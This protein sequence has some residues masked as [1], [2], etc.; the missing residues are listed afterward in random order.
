[1]QRRR[2]QVVTVCGLYAG[3]GGAFLSVGLIGNFTPNMTAGRGFIAIAAVI[4]GSW[5]VAG[6]LGATLIFGGADALRLALPAI[7]VEITPQLLIAAPYL[8]ALLTMLV[9]A[10]GRRQPRALGRGYEGLAA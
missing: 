5:A 2:R 6:T 3:L 10:Q 7:G 4:L 8:I 9:F 1:M